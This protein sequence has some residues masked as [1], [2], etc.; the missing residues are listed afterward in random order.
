[1]NKRTGGILALLGLAGGAFAYWKYR[2]M[3]EEEKAALKSKVK[4]VGKKIKETAT[5]VEQSVSETFT[6][7]KQK[8]KEEMNNMSS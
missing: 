8:A 6:D 4:N 2:N 3:S 1:M 7:L 5:E